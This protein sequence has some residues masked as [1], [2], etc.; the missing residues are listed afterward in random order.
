MSNSRAGFFFGVTAYVL[1]GLFPLYWPLLEPAG[2][3]EILAHR[4]FWSCLT[5]AVLVFA[6]RRVRQFR[7][8]LSDRR[9]FLLL[10]LAAC[11]VSLNWGT[12][13]WAVNND[14]VVESSL[15]YFINPL[16]TVLMGIVVLGER[17][18]R[19]QWL[20]MAIAA[21][22]VVVLTIEYGHPPWVALVLACSFGTYGLAKKLAGVDAIESMALETLLVA[23]FAAGYLAWLASRDQSHFAAEGTGHVLLLMSTGIVTAVPLLCFGAAAVRVPMVTIGLLQYLAPVLQFALGVLWFREDMPAGRW[24]GF[25]LVWIALILF[26]FEA[27]R[28]RR[29][30]LR[31]AADASAL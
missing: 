22:A 29:R 2:A 24:I 31:L 6:F 1:W 20:A 14:R 13:I 9:T 30:Q 16:V 26:T 21:S 28:H 11:V 12:Y 17:L 18:R 27:I 10:A 3:G 8:I 23:P 5:L 15:G 19:G 7:A 4:I 25:V